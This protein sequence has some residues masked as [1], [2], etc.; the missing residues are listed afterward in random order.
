V[1]YHL[2]LQPGQ[3]VLRKSVCRLEV[4]GTIEIIATPSAVI[5]RNLGKGRA[6]IAT[7]GKVVKLR[8]GQIVHVK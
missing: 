8:P 7:S 1:T 6:T 4:T 5:A 3:A 2:T